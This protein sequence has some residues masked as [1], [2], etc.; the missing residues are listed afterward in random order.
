MTLESGAAL[1]RLMPAA[2]QQARR[3]KRLGEPFFDLRGL[4]ARDTLQV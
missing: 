2:N 3:P 4:S 1:L